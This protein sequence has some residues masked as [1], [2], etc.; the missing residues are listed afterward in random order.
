MGVKKGLDPS[1]GVK[2]GGQTC[3][4]I[5]LGR[6]PQS[7]FPIFPK[8]VDRCNQGGATGV[9]REVKNTLRKEKLR[10]LGVANPQKRA[11]QGKRATLWEG[12]FSA[13]KKK[14]LVPWVQGGELGGKCNTFWERDT[15]EGLV[16]LAGK[17]ISM[18][19]GGTGAET[20]SE[21]SKYWSKI[22]TL[23]FLQESLLFFSFPDLFLLKRKTKPKLCKLCLVTH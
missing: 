6:G 11:L 12:N 13:G 5:G 16:C 7:L 21:S 17:N 1:R 9:G 14:G 23:F 10:E 22:I 2:Q 15:F 19:V 4:I 3:R 18:L 8:E 20:V